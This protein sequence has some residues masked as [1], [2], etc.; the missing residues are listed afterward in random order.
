M[1][2]IYD[3]GKPHIALE[4]SE[5]L[6]GIATLLAAKRGHEL[7]VGANQSGHSRL[8][9]EAEQREVAERVRELRAISGEAA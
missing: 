4:F 9:N 3:P 2:V 6:D 1:Y 5:T 7:T 8:L